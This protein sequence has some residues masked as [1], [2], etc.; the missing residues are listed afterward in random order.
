MARKP[1]AQVWD[2]LAFSGSYKAPAEG[3][4]APAFRRGKTAVSVAG[5]PI[6]A[7]PSVSVMVFPEPVRV[8]LIS[9]VT[10]PQFANCGIV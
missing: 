7:L 6:F 9:D 8:R 3:G 1:L 5:Y 10:S 2:S 4:R